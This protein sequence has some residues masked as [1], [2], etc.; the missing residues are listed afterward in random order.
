MNLTVEAEIGRGAFGTVFRVREETSGETFA[1]KQSELFESDGE[2]VLGTLREFVFYKNIRPQH[3]LCV[4]RKAWKTSSQAFFLL[5]LMSGNLLEFASLWKHK[6]PFADFVHVA[7]QL[8]HALHGLHAQGWMHRDIKPENVYVRVDGAVMLGDFSLV[9]FCDPQAPTA[10]SQ[11]SGGGASTTHVCTLWTRAPELVLADHTGVAYME[12]GHETDAFSVGATLL[13]LC[14]GGYV[15]GKRISSPHSDKTLAYL[16]GFFNSAGQ[17]A[18]IRAHYPDLDPADAPEFSTFARRLLGYLPACW[19]SEEKRM[20]ADILSSLLDPLPRR[21]ASLSCLLRLP[22]ATP[23]LDSFRQLERLAD[24]RKPVSTRFLNVPEAIPEGLPSSSSDT[25]WSLCGHWGCS[26]P[27]ALQ[28]VLSHRRGGRSSARALVR[29]LRLLHRFPMSS[30]AQDTTVAMKED[31]LAWLPFAAL[32]IDI[33]EAGRQ[34]EKSPF[35]ASSLAAHVHMKGSRPEDLASLPSK[36]LLKNEEADC[37]FGSFGNKWKS[38]MAMLE[39]W[40]RLESA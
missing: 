28:A 21:R 38:Q 30:S 11:Q 5:P 19:E 37:F 22:P 16:E 20:V 39:S 32:S 26:V 34:V 17:D 36:E 1:L 13:A 7:H 12:Y 6:L 24:I 25:L 15:F 23:N 27:F 8:A 29:L 3:G 14:A 4:A 18:L 9:R 31:M 2:L 10:G 33:W 35:L 40:R